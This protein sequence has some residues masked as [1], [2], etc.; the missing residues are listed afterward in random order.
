MSYFVL[1]RFVVRL[2]GTA[3]PVLPRAGWAARTTPN[4]TLEA[5]K[6]SLSLV[7]VSPPR[8]ER[9]TG[10]RPLQG[11]PAGGP[12]VPLQAAL[13]V[14]TVQGV[15]DGAFVCLFSSRGDAKQRPFRAGR[16]RGLVAWEVTQV[17]QQ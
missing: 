4:K 1:G 5:N 12:R 17:Q 14:P 8:K 6:R 9:V 3:K 15:F 10:W 13:L 11:P 7:S 2:A 16:S